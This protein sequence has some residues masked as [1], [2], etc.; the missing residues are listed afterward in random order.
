MNLYQQ[1]ILEHYHHPYHAGKPARF[2]HT[3]SVANLSCG[4]QVTMYLNLEGNFVK[5][6]HFEGE[7]CAISLATASILAECMEGKSIEEVENLTA[8]SVQDLIGLKL[9]ITR[10]KC[11]DI[12]R[13]ALQQATMSEPAS[14]GPKPQ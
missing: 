3:A 14:Q 11:A 4:D 12:V 6:V 5:E 8:D 1:N 13:E 2:T 10:I 7:G 9:S